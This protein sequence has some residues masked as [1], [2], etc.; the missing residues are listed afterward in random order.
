MRRIKTFWREF[1]EAS[2]GERFRNRYRSRAKKRARGEKLL[3]RPLILGLAGLSVLIALP[4]M[5]MPG[6]AVV[7]WGL[8]GFLL[9][10]E[11]AWV[12]RSLDWLELKVLERWRDWRRRRARRAP[13]ELKE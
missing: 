9:A 1:R 4:L 13:A 12:A 10:G 11:S 2:P 7:F 6:P 3:G 8:A 5:V